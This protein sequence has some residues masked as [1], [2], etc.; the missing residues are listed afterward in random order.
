MNTRQIKLFSILLAILLAITTVFDMSSFARVG[1]GRSFGSRGSR[2]Y[3]QPSRS[4]QQ[5]SPS[6]QQY[7]PSPTPYQPSPPRQPSGG[8]L[9]S[10]GGGI[11]GGFL[12]GM[13][14]RSLGFGSGGLGGGG[15]GLFEII[16][17][18]GIGYLVYRMITRRRK[19]SYVNQLPPPADYRMDTYPPAQPEVP[20]YSND[21]ADLSTGLAYIR[22]MDSSFDENRFRDL[23]MDIFFRIQ[24]AW[25]NR[26]LSPVIG[27]LDDE[28]R[29]I[30]QGDVDRLLRDRRIN[31]LENIA[32]RN[33]D[34]VEAWQESG[35]DFITVRFYA[36]LLDYTTDETGTLVEGNRTEPVK[37]EEYW[38]FTRQVG[39][40]SW[41]LSAISQA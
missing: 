34:L 16:L 4:Y 29:L 25:M 36:N 26:D 33:T 7:S 20:P 1:G 37:F 27:Y 38:T 23:A 9:R 8:F 5:P 14:F 10:L 24:G 22:Q 18:C 17:I 35:K 13:L 11:L 30:L 6:R 32:V 12:G 40:G 31:R 19:E 21:V 2:S 15:I 39:T 3:S 41:K 28:M